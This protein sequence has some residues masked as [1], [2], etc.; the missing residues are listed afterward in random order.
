MSMEL[1]DVVNKVRSLMNEMGEDLG[2]D[3][4]SEDTI[5]LSDYIGSVIPDAVNMVSRVSPLER[6]NAIGRDVKV[7]QVDGC[8]LIRLPDDFLRLSLLRL[9][10]WKRSVSLIYPSGSEMYAIQHN[11]HTT[12]GVNKPVCVFSSPLEVECF[13]SG[14]LERFLYIPL[15]NEYNALSVIKDTLFESVCYMCASLVYDIFENS[16]TASRLR[17]IALDLVK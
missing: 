5:R 14:R 8:S 13:P 16:N 3:L 11:E 6:L 12:A 4:L 17:S 10:G 15:A 9:T 1:R 7:S 2:P